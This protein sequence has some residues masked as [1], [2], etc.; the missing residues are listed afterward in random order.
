MNVFSRSSLKL[1][2]AAWNYVAPVKIWQD[3]EEHETKFFNF[4]PKT[5]RSFKVL[6]K[7]W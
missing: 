4:Y 3:Q 6:P 1:I 2:F 7:K 5:E